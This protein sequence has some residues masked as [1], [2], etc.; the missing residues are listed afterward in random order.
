[1]YDAVFSLGSN[2]E[3]AHQLRRNGIWHNRGPFDWMVTPFSSILKVIQDDGRAL[4]NSFTSAYNG[5]KAASQEY[6]CVYFHEFP[7]TEDGRGFIFNAEIERACKSK[8]QHKWSTLKTACEA[9]GKVLFI[10]FRSVTDVPGDEIAAGKK[11]GF[12]DLNALCDVIATRFPAL[13]FDLLYI[14][15]DNPIFD[16]VQTDD[17][18][19]PRVTI[20]SL[21]LAGGDSGN[22][23]DEAWD[24]I[25]REFGL[26]PAATPA[27]IAI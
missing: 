17:T 6:G 20:R 10:R 1:M 12:R 4:G 24:D 22:G 25:Y 16:I 14:H 7:P 13:E 8:M 19:D 11:F 3:P 26:I 21:E 5:T 27:S 23:A 2:C 9:P 15:G 18:L